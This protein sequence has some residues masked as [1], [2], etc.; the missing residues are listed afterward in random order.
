MSDAVERITPPESTPGGLP[1][2][3]PIS[4]RRVGLPDVQAPGR[5]YV[6]ARLVGRGLLRLIFNVRVEGA[7]RVPRRGAVLLAG[8]HRGMLD[9]PVTAAVTPRGASFLAKSELFTGRLATVL[10]RLGQIPVD[11]GRTD[12][13]ALR[14]AIAVLARGDVLG[15]FPEGT[16]GS[17]TLEAVQHGVGYVLVKAPGTVVVPVACL[18]TERAWPKGTRWPRW[19]APVTV[20]FGEPFTV[21]PTGDPRSRRAAAETAEVVRVRL[22]AHLAM[23]EARHAARVGA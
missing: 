2:A 8:N 14:R 13:E 7:R 11:R 3:A 16:R 5:L 17:G 19:R 23:A 18:G 20:V 22:A 21:E 12:R 1:T 9:G 15:L 10:P 4:V 6:A